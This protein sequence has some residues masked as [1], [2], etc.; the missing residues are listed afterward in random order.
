MTWPSSQSDG[1]P[2]LIGYYSG[3][4]TVNL[5][6]AV[7]PVN[8]DLFVANTEARNLVRFEPNLRGHWVDNR[9]T[10]IQLSTAQVTP[11]D[12]E[13][14]TSTIRSC[15]TR[16]R[17]RRRSPS[18]RPWCSIRPGGFMHVAA[19]GTDRVAQVDTNGKVMSFVEVS[20]PSGSGSNVDP[21]TKRGPRGL[22]LSAD[23]RTLYVLNRISN[24][25]SVI[26]TVANSRD[27][28]APGRDRPDAAGHPRRPRVSL[29]C[30]A[31]RKRHRLMCVVS[32]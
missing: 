7:N 24:T 14:G 23:G 2:R 29:R 6:L 18:R 12:S 20:P 21:R 22:A 16:P 17:A 3:V 27:S 19:F 32:R 30:Q 8:G 11:F 13:S 26:D 4:G 15:R 25:I 31:L 28:R 5:G 1:V 9:I 10:R